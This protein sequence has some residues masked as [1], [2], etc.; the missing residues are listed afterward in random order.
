[1]ETQLQYYLDGDNVLNMTGIQKHKNKIYQEDICSLSKILC[2]TL[3]L[4]F[5]QYISY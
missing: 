3:G 4:L 2:F 5:T 1:M